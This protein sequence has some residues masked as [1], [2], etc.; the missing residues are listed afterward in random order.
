MSP[1]FGHGDLVVGRRGVVP[2]ERGTAVVFSVDRQAYEAVLDPTAPPDR[3]GRVV[4]GRGEDP[5]ALTRRLKRV[6]AVGGCPAPTV[7]PRHL[8]EKYG[9]LVPPGHIAVAGDNPNSEGSAQFGYVAL[10][11]V[12][13][14]I[15]G[16]LRR[17]RSAHPAGQG[18]ASV[19]RSVASPPEVV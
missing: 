2:I 18:K 9:G 19:G 7:L 6:I 14:V 16:R 3:P 12:E 17:R 5:T 15:L 1:A 4:Y 13:S 11:R 8:R 10:E